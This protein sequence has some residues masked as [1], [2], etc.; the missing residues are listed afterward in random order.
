MIISYN[1]ISTWISAA[2][3]WSPRQTPLGLSRSRSSELGVPLQ[4]PLLLLSTSYHNVYCCYCLF[5]IIMF[6]ITITAITTIDYYF[7]YY[8]R[9][10]R[11]GENPHC[12]SL[13]STR[14]KTSVHN[15]VY[16]YIHIH[17]CIYIYIYI[18]IYIYMYIYTEYL[19]LSI[20]I[21]IV[22]CL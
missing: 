19:S 2:S 3:T 9:G 10:D 13:G 16:I 22:T 21:Y 8:P 12:W 14:V 4:D 20:Y 6:V 1:S 18:C 11:R 15:H 5:I 17:A 7:C